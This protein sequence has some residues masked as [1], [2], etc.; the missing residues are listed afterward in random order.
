MDFGGGGVCGFGA[1]FGWWW[2][3]ANRTQQHRVVDW[4]GWLVGYTL[5]IPKINHPFLFSFASSH[6]VVNVWNFLPFFSSWGAL[7]QFSTITMSSSRDRLLLLL[8]PPPRING[9]R[10]LAGIWGGGPCSSRDTAK[11]LLS[12]H[13]EDADDWRSISGDQPR[14]LTLPPLR[15]PTGG[16][17]VVGRISDWCSSSSVSRSYV[18]D[19][20][21]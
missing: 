11:L 17:G 8:P 5:H 14:L 20:P 7:T 2:W 1:T 6:S 3:L 12:R 4:I 18:E 16:V 9:W 13:G 19:W 10:V 21:E 15:C